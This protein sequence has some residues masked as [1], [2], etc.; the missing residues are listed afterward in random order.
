MGTVLGTNDTRKAWINRLA[1][2][3]EYRRRAIGARLVRECERVLRKRGLE[4]FAALIEPDNVGSAAF[5]RSL[6]YDILPILY[7]RKKRRES[8]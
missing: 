8:V 5:F 6:G 1:V 4:M 2:H 3:P 7:A